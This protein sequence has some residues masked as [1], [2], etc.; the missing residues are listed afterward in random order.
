[1]QFI[2][3]V[4]KSIDDSKN[5][6]EEPSKNMLN[7]LLL[8]CEANIPLG[9]STPF[10]SVIEAALALFGKYEEIYKPKANDDFEL[11][12][13]LYNNIFRR[14]FHFPKYRK[15]GARSVPYYG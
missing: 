15:V 5:N 4:D 8:L 9:F 6:L 1:M 10:T 12:T 7:L 3:T 2:S 14:I 13:K 11:I